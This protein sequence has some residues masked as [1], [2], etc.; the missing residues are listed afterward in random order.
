MVKIKV[1]IACKYN[2]KV[3][4]I[5][6]R[7]AIRERCLNCSGWSRSEVQGCLIRS[8]TLFHY[9]KGTGKQ[10][11]KARNKAIRDYCLWCSLDQRFEM[12][13]CTA[14]DCP[15]F[16]FR[17]SSLDRSI[18]LALNSKTSYIEAVSRAIL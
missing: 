17:K 7:K 18:D 16:P 4:N 12:L 9:R 15:L 10:D 2:H 11:A 13:E 3:I 1:K 6:R 14:R 8:C 5:N